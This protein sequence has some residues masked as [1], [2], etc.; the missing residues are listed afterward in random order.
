MATMRR[1]P[2]RRTT[3]LGI[4]AIAFSLLYFATDAIE[5]TADPRLLRGERGAAALLEQAA[6]RATQLHGRRVGRAGATLLQAAQLAL[7][8]RVARAVAAPGE[9]SLL[10]LAVCGPDQD[11]GKQRRSDT[12]SGSILH[13]GSR[14]DL[15][16]AATRYPCPHPP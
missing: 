13:R 6:S 5:A 12:T 10:G 16:D 8:H 9:A 4:C 15:S 3:A 14:R 2:D 11:G 7:Q 1:M